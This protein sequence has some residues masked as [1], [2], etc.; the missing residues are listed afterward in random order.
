MANSKGT[1]LKIMI[2]SKGEAVT[3]GHI[4]TPEERAEWR[5]QMFSQRCLDAVRANP[6]CSGGKS[7]SVEIA[8][9]EKDII[10]VVI[11]QLA[12]AGYHARRRNSDEGT[13]PYLLIFPADPHAAAVEHLTSKCIE[14]LQK[15]WTSV[16]INGVDDDVVD[17]VIPKLRAAGWIAKRRPLSEGTYPLLKIHS[18]Q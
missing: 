6:T 2:I 3:K 15:N 4:P 13:H 10:D 16:D 9:I 18:Q 8:D 17:A 14:A 1:D 12:E 5:L 11:G 7:L